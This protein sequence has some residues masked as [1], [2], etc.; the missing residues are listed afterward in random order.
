MAKTAMLRARLEPTLKKQ[1]ERVLARVGLT[2][3]EAVRL[4]YKQVYLAKGLPFEVRI[5]N[6]TTRRAVAEAR[7]GKPL[8]AFKSAAE[9]VRSTRS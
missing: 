9:L 1:A 3:T 8:R 2:P 7:S 4:F 5:P 6:A